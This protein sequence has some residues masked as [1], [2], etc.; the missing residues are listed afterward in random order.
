MAIA[1]AGLNIVRQLSDENSLES[2]VER[3][4]CSFSFLLEHGTLLC[5]STVLINSLVLFQ[6]H[7]SFVLIQSHGGLT[8]ACFLFR[9]NIPCRFYTYFQSLFC[10]TC[11]TISNILYIKSTC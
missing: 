3:L 9:L 7:N 6:F 10:T 1:F 2:E 5:A 11:G 8:M 4:A